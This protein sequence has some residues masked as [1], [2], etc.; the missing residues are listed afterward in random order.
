M[1]KFEIKETKT[2]FVFN[3]KAGNG[4]V[5]A[6]SQVYKSKPT[7]KRGVESVRKNC[8]VKVET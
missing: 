5:I 1:G 2:G 8:A 3:L 4:Q 7:C 6:T